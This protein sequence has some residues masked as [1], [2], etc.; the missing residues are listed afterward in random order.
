MKHPSNTIE[1]QMR[2]KGFHAEA[3]QVLV[4]QA[5]PFLGGV[6]VYMLLLVRVWPARLDQL[7][8]KSNLIFLLVIQ[9]PNTLVMYNIKFLSWVP[10]IS[11]HLCKCGVAFVAASMCEILC[12]CIF[13][14]FRLYC[15]W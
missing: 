2:R 11:C 8:S 9:L 14:N 12:F 15:N 6:R 10:K 5:R 4:S 7:C 1:I 13:D 3:G